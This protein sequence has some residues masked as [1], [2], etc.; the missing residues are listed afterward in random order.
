MIYKGGRQSSIKAV[1]AKPEGGY[2]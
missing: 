2:A 1:T